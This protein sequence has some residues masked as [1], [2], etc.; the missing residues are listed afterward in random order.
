M[1]K[2][3]QDQVQK[4]KFEETQNQEKDQTLHEDLQSLQLTML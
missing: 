4:Q 3:L 2:T 1:N